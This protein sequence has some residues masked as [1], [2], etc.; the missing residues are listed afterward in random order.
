M[1]EIVSSTVE[2]QIEKLKSRHLIISDES[3]AKY[4]LTLY[5][6]SN[7]IKSY[8]EPY[9]YTDKNL[10]LFREGVSFEQI[11][12]LYL[13]DKNLRNAIMASMLDYE[14]FI[15]EAAANIISKSFGT[16]QDDYLKF[17]NYKNKK[18]RV[19]RFTLKEIL[20]SMNRSLLTDKNPIFHYRETYGIVPP[21]ILFKSIYLS[22][23]INFIDLFKRNEAQ[24]MALC[25]YN[26]DITA[27]VDETIALM[28][29]TMF[30]CMEYRNIAAH[31][32]RVYNYSCKNWKSQTLT[33]NNNGSPDGINKLLFLLRLLKYPAPYE[34]VYRVLNNEI[35][36]H[37]KKYPS[38]VTYLGQCLKANIILEANIPESLDGQQCRRE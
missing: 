3:S 17:R 14:E 33:K 35:S 31:G 20:N 8:R 23:M 25:L 12:S 37:C 26:D 9:V 24:A 22:T 6:Y 32:G 38:D 1:K 13:L 27:S 4:Y 7:L 30:V 2:Q 36:R 10:K 11:C 18:K 21:W 34:H 19:E 16:N 28:M 29:N 5:G 15:K